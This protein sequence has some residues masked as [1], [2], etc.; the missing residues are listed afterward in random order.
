MQMPDFEKF[1]WNEREVRDYLGYLAA[2]AE[3][4]YAEFSARGVNSERPVLGVRVPT[5]RKIAREIDRGAPEEFLKINPV[6]LE[7][8]LVTLMVFARKAERDGVGLRGLKKFA[9]LSDS[10]CT[11]DILCSELKIVKKQPEKFLP[12]VDALL[13]E[14]NQFLVRTGVVLLL[15]YYV[16]QG[17]LG[18]V[19]DRIF[20]VKD[21]PEYYIKMAVAWLIQ[22]CYVHFP[23]DTFHAVLKSPELP[24]WVKRKAVSKIQDSL[25]ISP[26]DKALAKSV[27]K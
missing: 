17:Y 3:P 23:E 12:M 16:T 5:L 8:T 27:F 22:V 4:E 9:G 19:F 10:W 18:V 21:R 7:E 24:D 14:R 20:L 26:E 13:G 11:T 15:S 25:R 2:L 1:T 6:S